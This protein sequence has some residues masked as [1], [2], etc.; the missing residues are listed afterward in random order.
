MGWRFYCYQLAL[1]GSL[2][3]SQT[4]DGNTEGGAGHIVQ[5]D[6]V[7][8]LNRV[9]VAAVLTTDTVVQLVAGSL[10]LGNSHLHQH[11]NAGLIQLSEG[12]VLVNLGVV[13]S[14]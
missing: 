14:V 3:G 1:D 10:C 8:E 5:T 2:G 12:I 4:G 6:L 13:V 7:A 9:G 11:A